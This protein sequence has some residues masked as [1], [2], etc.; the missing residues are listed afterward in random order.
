MRESLNIEAIGRSRFYENNSSKIVQF[1]RWSNVFQQF[2]NAADSAA[3]LS[4][5]A[6]MANKQRVF[7]SFHEQMFERS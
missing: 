4:H 6:E 3:L 2:A 1:I 7:F 5:L